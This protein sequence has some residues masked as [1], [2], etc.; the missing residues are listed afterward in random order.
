M[1][2]LTLKYYQGI[3]HYIVCEK[4]APENCKFLE[5]L[6]SFDVPKKCE[7]S[8]FKKK[9]IFF[10]YYETEVFDVIDKYYII[11]FKEDY[12]KKH[13]NDKKSFYEINIINHKKIL[14]SKDIVKYGYLKNVLLNRGSSNISGEWRNIECSIYNPIFRLFVVEEYYRLY[15]KSVYD[16]CLKHIYYNSIF[17]Y[18]KL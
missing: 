1:K 10:D 7:K 8:V 4:Y 16:K 15:Y 17:N 12:I 5:V 6:D 3:N 14:Q 11:T 18:N 9:G 13:L 2:E